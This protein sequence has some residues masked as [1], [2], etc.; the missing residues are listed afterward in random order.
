MDLTIQ[1]ATIEDAPVIWGVIQA[2]FKEYEGVLFPPPGALRETAEDIARKMSEPGGAILAWADGKPVGAAR[3]SR[4]D[5]YLFIGRVSVLPDYQRQGIGK[6][7]VEYIEQLAT[8]N[9]LPETKL[10]V[11]LSIPQN[12]AFYKH[13]R[14]EVVEEHEYPDKSDR[15]YIMS[16]RL[17]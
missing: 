3:Y 13:L 2:A 17:G 9:C 1:K 11:R 7:L 16:K 8:A 6:R 5:G 15:W 12:V 10:G 14:Y 4:D